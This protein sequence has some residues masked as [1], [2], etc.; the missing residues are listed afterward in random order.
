MPTTYDPL[1]PEAQALREQ[2]QAHVDSLSFQWRQ[3][4]YDYGYAVVMNMARKY[5]DYEECRQELLAI[6]GAPLRSRKKARI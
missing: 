4:I 1:S 2:R 6:K 5:Q 3:L